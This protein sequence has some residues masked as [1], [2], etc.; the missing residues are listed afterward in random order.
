MPVLQLGFFQAI[1]TGFSDTHRYSEDQTCSRIRTNIWFPLST[2]ILVLRL[3]VK[4]Q[5]SNQSNVVVSSSDTKL[6]ASL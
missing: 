6:F 2:A 4:T 5:G 3:I 1:E